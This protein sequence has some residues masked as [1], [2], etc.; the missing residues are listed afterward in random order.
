MSIQF[1][2]SNFTVCRPGCLCMTDNPSNHFAI[3][4]C[5]FSDI[6]WASPA[7]DRQ[8]SSSIITYTWW[9]MKQQHQVL[10]TANWNKEF[11]INH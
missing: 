6:L 1:S 2:H 3:S 5:I 10:D 9:G 11:Q 4:G 8:P 7:F